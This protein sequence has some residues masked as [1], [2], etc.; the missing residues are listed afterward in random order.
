MFALLDQARK[1]RSRL[2]AAPKG[3]LAQSESR[4]TRA[5]LIA[6][7]RNAFDAAWI[8]EA[9]RARFLKRLEIFARQ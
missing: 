4:L 7:S 8:S 2:E 6:V 9:Q 1:M 3:D 5:A